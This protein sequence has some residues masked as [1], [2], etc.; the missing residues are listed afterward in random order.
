MHLVWEN[1]I[2]LISHRKYRRDWLK[3]IRMYKN[4]QTNRLLILNGFTRTDKPTDC[5]SKIDSNQIKRVGWELSSPLN[6]GQWSTTF[7]SG[8]NVDGQVSTPYIMESHRN[9]ENSNLPSIPVTWISYWF[10]WFNLFPSTLSTESNSQ[11]QNN[12]SE[13]ISGPT[14]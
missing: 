12:I 9:P 11:F 4:G 7:Y 14:F 2:I 10:V 13:F 8:L 5:K 1:L 3:T 6:H